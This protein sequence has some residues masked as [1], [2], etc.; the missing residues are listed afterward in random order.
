LEKIDH[1]YVRSG[2]EADLEMRFIP[3]ATAVEAAISG[4]IRNQIAVTALL[5]AYVA[6]S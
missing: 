1:D 2:E 6:R 5:A 4:K 3:L